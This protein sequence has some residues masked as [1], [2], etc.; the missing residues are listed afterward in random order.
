MGCGSFVWIS[1]LSKSALDL[2][3]RGANTQSSQGQVSGKVNNQENILVVA[4]P[5]PDKYYKTTLADLS[6]NCAIIGGGKVCIDA[7]LNS[8][9]IMV[10]G[11]IT[12]TTENQG[13]M[14]KL[15]KKD[16]YDF[17]SLLQVFCLIEKNV[18]MLKG[19]IRIFI[20]E[21]TTEEEIKKLEIFKNKLDELALKLKVEYSKHSPYVDIQNKLFKKESE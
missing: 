12:H 5:Y 18:E 15:S 6:E 21:S 4:N 8:N 10:G 16:E 11:V 13:F 3:F 2:A 17:D 9:I 19:D 14:I 7:E 20:K 1:N